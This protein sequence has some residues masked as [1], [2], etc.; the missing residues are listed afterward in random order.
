[1]MVFATTARD[2][3][4]WAFSGFLLAA[5]IAVPPSKLPTVDEQKNNNEDRLAMNIVKLDF[6]WDLDSV[7]TQVSC[8]AV[9]AVLLWLAVS[10]L[11]EFVL[12]RIFPTLRRRQKEEEEDNE[13][14]RRR[15]RS[16]WTTFGI[17]LSI[18]G[19]ALRMWSK[20]VLGK[21]FK[22]RIAPPDL[23]DDDEGLITSGPYAMLIHPGYSGSV[24]HAAGISVLGTLCLRRPY[25]RL[26]VANVVVLVA[27]VTSLIQIRI[28]DEETMLMGHFGDDVWT[29]H[30]DPRWRLIPYVY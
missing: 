7:F 18:F 10:L 16:L 24:I 26:A 23:D 25:G 29:A 21:H 2:F 13:K 4:P 27:I 20:I 3:V 19:F 5:E 17:A 6:V 15:G 30:V 28:H 12:F 14:E 11:T 8:A 1:M 9:F 22:Y